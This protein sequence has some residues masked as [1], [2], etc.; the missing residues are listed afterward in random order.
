MRGRISV[1]FS[2]RDALRTMGA[3]FG[4]TA[5]AAM[6][7]NHMQAASVA[8]TNPWAPKAPHFPAKAKHVIFVFLNGGL[9]QVDSFDRKPMLDKYDGKPLPY[10][11]P[12][13]EFAT[14]NLMKSPF[15]FQQYGHNGTWVSEIF[16]K[17]GGIIDE[18]CIVRSMRS[19]IPNHAPSIMMMNTGVSRVGRPSMGSWI[20]YG[21]GT[22]NQNLPGFIVLISGGQAGDAS[23]YG[24]AFL[25]SVYQGTSVP[26][27]ETDPK[28]QIEYLANSKLSLGQQREQLDYV[29]ALNQMHYDRAGGAPELES[30]IQSMEVAFRM[31]TEAPDVFDLTKENETTRKRYGDSEFGRSCLMARRLVA[32][33]VRMVQLYHSPWDHHSD[34]MGHKSSAAEV[35]GPIATLVQDLKENGLF[36][37]TLVVV[38]SEFGRTPVL[39]TGGFLTVHNGR[40]HNV[41]AFTV[42]LAGGGSKAGSIYGTT[43]DFGFKVA[44]NPVHVH[45]LHAT[46]LHL[47]GLNHE[48]LTYQYSGR[49]FRLTDVEGNVVRGILG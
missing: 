30:S 28:K 37:D 49:N 16:P 31:Q 25:P 43:D 22:E 23:K 17:I 33:G 11:T 10:E 2:R 9:S 35:D 19:E 7:G 39:N 41:H 46:T 21:L 26:I 12:R 38:G 45:D 47:L 1:P 32:R 4:M 14:G 34:I 29:Q 8:S 40:D 36:D 5:L 48:K 27:K 6:A 44:E 24:S 18:F 3:G 13:T 42:L 20:V 15:T